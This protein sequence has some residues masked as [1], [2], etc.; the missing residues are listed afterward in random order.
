MSA[1]TLMQTM[2]LFALTAAA[3]IFGCG[4]VWLWARQQASAWWLVLAAASLAT[5]AWLLTL[6]PAASGRIYAAYG[7]IYVDCAIA[8]LLAV[9]GI[10]PNRYDLLGLTC[11]LLGVGIIVAGNW[12]RP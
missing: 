7:G 8:W 6:H 11:M 12:L 4:L 2:G 3:E 5:F 10:T 1:S 9:D